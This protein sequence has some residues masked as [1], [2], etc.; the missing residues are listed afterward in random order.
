[1]FIPS[2]EKK[3]TSMKYIRRLK[4]NMELQK[5]KAESINFRNHVMQMHKV[6]SYDNEFSRTRGE[7][8]QIEQK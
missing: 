8:T 5:A 3:S 1:M 6:A 4:E 7:L 2:D